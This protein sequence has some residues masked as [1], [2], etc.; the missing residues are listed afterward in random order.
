MATHYLDVRIT[1][2]A[3]PLYAAENFSG[4][5]MALGIT[6]DNSV[7][8][9]Y[10]T[11]V[12]RKVENVL[13]GYRNVGIQEFGLYPIEESG[14][15]D[16]NNL[17]N[18]TVEEEIFDAK[19]NNDILSEIEN[20]IFNIVAERGIVESIVVQSPIIFTLLK[21]KVDTD[22]LDW[23]IILREDL[24]CNFLIRYINAKN[25]TMEM[26]ELGN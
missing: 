24:D 17:H 2:D 8:N 14:V 13:E 11:A 23:E 20:H 26:K 22:Y 12:L 6:D 3:L 9:E 4:I 1:I 19:S 10:A 18:I 21:T 25:K 16:P 5:K 7:L 15:N